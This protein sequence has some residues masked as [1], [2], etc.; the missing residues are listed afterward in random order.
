MEAEVNLYCNE[1]S[2]KGSCDQLLTNQIQRLL[3]CMDVY[4]E[5]ESTETQLEGPLEFP[6]ERI[7]TR[8]S[9]YM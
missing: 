4:L 3:M 8:S 6:K 7:Y 9:R 2:K 5:L 1:L